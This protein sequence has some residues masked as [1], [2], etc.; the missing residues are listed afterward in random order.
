MV[1]GGY[2]AAGAVR[3][4]DDPVLASVLVRVEARLARA[5]GLYNTPLLTPLFRRLHIPD[6][7]DACLVVLEVPLVLE[8]ELAAIDTATLGRSLCSIFPLLSP[9]LFRIH[10]PDS[11]LQCLMLLEV[12]LILGLELAAI[13]TATLDRLSC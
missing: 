5:L 1:D 9:Q 13:D 6:S 10:I 11:M 8:L 4:G 7:M 2:G 3:G 12:M